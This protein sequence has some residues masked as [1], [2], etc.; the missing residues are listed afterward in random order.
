MA[1]Y[2]K[3][4]TAIVEAHQWFPGTKSQVVIQMEKPIRIGDMEFLA[5]IKTLEDTTE[6]YHYVRAGDYI[7]TGTNNDVWAV[8]QD[9]FE[10]T[11]ELVEEPI[12]P[13]FN[14]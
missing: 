14:C 6:S 11:Y 10:N 12:E 1:K 5:K 4:A 3:K 8:K 13:D 9:I 2:R 7:V